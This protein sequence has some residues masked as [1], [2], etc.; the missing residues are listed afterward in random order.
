MILKFLNNQ[1]YILFSY[2]IGSIKKKLQPNFFYLFFLTLFLN[3]FG[4]FIDYV[5]VNYLIL[6][7][8]LI[9][10]FTNNIINFFFSILII[11]KYLLP[12]FL[13]Y[14]DFSHTNESPK[15]INNFIFFS[16]TSIILLFNLNCNL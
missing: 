1:L 4:Y 6:L 3:I 14:N 9:L 10:I 2:T 8:L 12:L 15:L 11:I 16:S 7:F 5:V 13:D